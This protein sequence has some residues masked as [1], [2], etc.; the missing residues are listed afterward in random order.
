[1]QLYFQ[2]PISQKHAAT[3]CIPKN[4]VSQLGIHFWK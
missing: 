3:D 1:M 2:I 4:N